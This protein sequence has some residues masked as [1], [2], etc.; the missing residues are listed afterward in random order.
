MRTAQK[1]TGLPSTW[2]LILVAVLAACGSDSSNGQTV[3]VNLSLVVDGRQ[4]QHRPAVSRLFA[5][6]ERWFPGATPAWAQSVSE[7]ASI[8]V[9]I[10][11]PGIPSPAT[12]TVP[13]SDPTSGQEIPVSIQA[14]VGPESNHHGDSVQCRIATSEDLRGNA[15]R[16]ELDRRG[17]NQSRDHARAALHGYRAKRGRWQWHGDFLAGRHRLWCH[18][19]KPVSRGHDGVIECRGGTWFCVRWLERCVLGHGTLQRD[20][21]CHRHGTLY[22]SDFHRSA[23][24]NPRGE[25]DRHCHQ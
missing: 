6:I 25:W 4:A 8:Q 7:I 14:P 9:Q 24:G 1:S 11:G 5:W 22:C 21:Q 13:V 3:A 2:G 18:L 17:A 20:K 16:R 23:D 19:R 15:T 12:T 10:T